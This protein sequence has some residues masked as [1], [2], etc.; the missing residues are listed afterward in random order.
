MEVS[1]EGSCGFEMRRGCALG[2]AA[3]VNRLECKCKGPSGE[4]YKTQTVAC[5]GMVISSSVFMLEE[6]WGWSSKEE[7]L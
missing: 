7:A 2:G 1:C 3:A 5:F 6:I 4:T